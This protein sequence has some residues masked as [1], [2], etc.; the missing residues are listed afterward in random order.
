MKKNLLGL[1]GSILAVI[2]VFFLG[3]PYLFYAYNSSSYYS[4]TETVKTSVQSLLGIYDKS[5]SAYYGYSSP[6]MG[7]ILLVVSFVCAF[8]ALIVVVTGIIKNKNVSDKVLILASVNAFTVLWFVKYLTNILSPEMSDS[9][10]YV[11]G[12]GIVCILGL[13]FAFF[14]LA[15]AG[16]INLIVS[17]NSDSKEKNYD[18]IYKLKKLLDDG[19]ITKEEFDEKK[20][21]LLG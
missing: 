15:L 17:K 10:S 14:V 4:S 6:S 21:Q 18:D 13:F 20:N 3:S 7:G 2:S 1:I 9:Y 19:I 11:L 5:S 8:I 12:W 16:F